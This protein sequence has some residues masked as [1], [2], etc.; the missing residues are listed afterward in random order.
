[1]NLLCVLFILTTIHTEG[2]KYYKKCVLFN[3]TLL[4]HRMKNWIKSTLAFWKKNG[5]LSFDYKRRFVFFLVH[6]L[7]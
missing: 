5:P 7:L 1:M 4:F 2:N 3:L 6:F